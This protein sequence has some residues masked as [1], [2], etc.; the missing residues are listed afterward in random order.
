HN[1]INI[2]AR[3]LK[4]VLGS[5]DKSLLE[6]IFEKLNEK[7][8]STNSLTIAE[9]IKL[10]DKRIVF[11]LAFTSHLKDDLL[12]ENNID[13]FTSNIAKFSLVQCSSDLRADYFDLVVHQ[14]R[15]NN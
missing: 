2:S 11:V 3:R 8:L 15:R 9:F 4:D 13:R 5:S 6:K 12:V 10:F 7:G 1:Q 14:I